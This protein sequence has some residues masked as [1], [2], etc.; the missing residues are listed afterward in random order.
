MLK[1][2]ALL[3]HLRRLE[4]DLAEL[5]LKNNKYIQKLRFVSSGTEAVMSAIRLASGYTEA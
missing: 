2:E 4:N 1:K 5:I 3:V